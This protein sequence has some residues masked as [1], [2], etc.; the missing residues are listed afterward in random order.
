MRKKLRSMPSMQCIWKL[1]V[2]GQ[3]KNPSFMTPYVNYNANLE[4]KLRLRVKNCFVTSLTA[5]LKTTFQPTSLPSS[6]RHLLWLLSQ[7]NWTTSL[8]QVKLKKLNQ[9]RNRSISRPDSLQISK[10]SKAVDK[11]AP[12]PFQK[13]NSE[14]RITHHPSKSLKD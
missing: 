2:T 3:A 11:S 12:T 10:N 7:I 8:G 9:T 5:I 14:S 1:R 6:R 4:L 13:S